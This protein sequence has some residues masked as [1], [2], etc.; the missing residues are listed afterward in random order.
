[1]EH[2][3]GFHGHSQDHHRYSDFKS[4][5]GPARGGA[6]VDFGLRK[7]ERIIDSSSAG[8]QP[9]NLLLPKNYQVSEPKVH[10]SAQAWSSEP[11]RRLVE[12]RHP[13][14]PERTDRLQGFSL[15][16]LMVSVALL[17]V[18]AGA[19]FLVMMAHQKLS[20]TQHL[21]ADMYLSIRGATELM[22]QEIGQAGL[23]TLPPSQ[24]SAA[25]TASTSPRTVE[26]TSTTSMYVGE[27]LLV[28]T[29]SSQELVTVTALNTSPSQITGVFNNNHL[30]GAVINA[31]GVFPQGVMSSSTADQLQ[32][33]GDIHGDGSLVYIHYDCNATAGTLSRSVTPVTPTV[34]ASNASQVLLNNLI[35]N[36]GATPC[37]QITTTTVGSNT[38]VTN[39]ALTLSVKTSAPDPQTGAYLTMTKSYQN[40]APRNVLAGLEL[41]NVP[42]LDRLQ[43]TPPNLPL[44]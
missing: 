14:T 29:A 12:R 30:S 43:P 25:V 33:F 15:L 41:A 24:L 37:F 26:I 35:A 10:G 18:I 7:I 34:S 44:P 8:I 42:F 3:D 28:D 19:V 17:L 27:K 20:A 22:T 9:R 23:V 21:K 40:L 6:F 13:W 31:L 16:E 2:L 11:E 1:M 39:V 32:L 38:F 4:A 5:G 36:P